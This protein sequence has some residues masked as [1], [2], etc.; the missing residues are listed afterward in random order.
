M[1]NV[2][3]YPYTQNFCG[4]LHGIKRPHKI[5]PIRQRS[6]PWH[7]GLPHSTV[8]TLPTE[9]AK[10]HN[11]YDSFS[12]TC[13][14]IKANLHLNAVQTHPYHTIIMHLQTVWCPGVAWSHQWLSWPVPLAGG[15]WSVP[16]WSCFQQDCSQKQA[17]H[18]W[19]CTK[20]GR[21]VPSHDWQIN[22]GGH[23]K[24]NERSRIHIWL[25]HLCMYRHD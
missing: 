23:M 19:H 16:H 11:N 1:Y 22:C 20:N 17:T 5:N 14:E 10:I 15:S 21:I 6:N 18:C 9:T 24:V 8:F 4:N 13:Y 3:K 12:L 7:C 25:H 2:W